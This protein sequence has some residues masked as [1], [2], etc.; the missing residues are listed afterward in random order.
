MET[1][2]NV[3]VLFALVLAL[4]LLIERLLEI[5][6]AIYSLADSRLNWYIFWTRKTQRLK[7]RLEKRLRIFTFTDPEDV[8][9]VFHRF[10]EMLMSQNMGYSGTVP[11]LCGDLVRMAY[12]KTVCKCIAMGLGVG[13][14]LWLKI[15][16]MAIWQNASQE[17]SKWQI[18]LTS[19]TLRMI[20]SGIAIGLGSGPVHKIITVIERKKEKQAAK[21]AQK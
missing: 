15:D 11:I 9:S 17:P 1:L 19:P 16:L 7:D 3:T 21:G 2:L 12:I 13:L 5:L 18:T 20:F 4:S 14:A 6:K 8:A 10:R